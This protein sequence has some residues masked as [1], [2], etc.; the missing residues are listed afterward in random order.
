[1]SYVTLKERVPPA[2][3]GTGKG[4]YYN[5]TTGEPHFI[6]D[7]GVDMNVSPNR[8][9]NWLRNSGFW[10]AQRQVPTTLTTYSNVGG[11]AITA[12]GWGIS[13]ENASVQYQQ[14]D[15]VGAPETGLQGKYYGNFTKI[16]STG[17]LA[18]I[19][20]VEG[21]DSDVLRG[22][23]VR[24]QLWAKSIVAAS[25]TW[26]MF[27]VSFGLT[28][29]TQDVIPINAGT[30]FTAFGAN[31]VDPTL[32]TQL[33]YTAPK[34]TVT[35][36]NCTING[37]GLDMTVTSAWQRFGAVF[38]VSTAA[39]NLAIVIVSNNQVATT[40]GIA[41]S[42]VSLTEGMAVQDWAPL[43]VEEELE[44]VQRYYAKSFPL[45]IAP[46]Q[47]AGT[48]GAVRGYVSVAGATANQPIGVRFPV[49]LRITPTAMTFYNPSA[50]NAFTRNTTA[51]TDATATT[52][53][54]PSESGTD[55][56]FTGIAAW[57]VG[58]AVAVHY[59]ADVE[60]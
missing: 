47:N 13:N 60:L 5:S 26:R 9:F 45:L 30:F 4:V 57:T 36:D 54:T 50:A 20:V 16:T 44:R 2:T 42:Q 58:Q 1:M 32:G 29:G 10:F 15:T 51:A 3:P 33:S 24:V 53:S 27:L 49:P 6:N 34:A 11:R 41:L 14:T 52:M 48:T 19:Q 55:I 22:S 56:F 59:T 18:V 17:K 43:S 8:K 23:S 38:D 40:N 31:G 7:D 39:K 25:A 37:N 46:A 21:A 28:G 12:D 35:P